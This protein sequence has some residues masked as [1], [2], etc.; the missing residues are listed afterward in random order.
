MPV[1]EIPLTNQNQT[2]QTSLL[3][4]T[5]T[6]TVRWNALA[7]LWYL[8]INDVNNKPLLNGLPM[9]AGVNLLKQFGYLGLGGALVALNGNYP[10]LPIGYDD[11][12]Q[13]SFLLF[14]VAK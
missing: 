6:L 3:G 2:L 4:V 9:T 11:L 10:T 1:Y 12:G 5:Y 8:D 13:T 7:G 14:I